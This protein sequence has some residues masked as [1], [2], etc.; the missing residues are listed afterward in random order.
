MASDLDWFAVTFLV[1]P[2]GQRTHRGRYVAHERECVACKQLVLLDDPLKVTDSS[3][4]YG[5]MDDCRGLFIYSNGFDGNGGPGVGDPVTL[6]RADILLSNGDVTL[7][8]ENY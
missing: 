3:S 2:L 1:A 5:H 7:G 8:T 4:D 6:A